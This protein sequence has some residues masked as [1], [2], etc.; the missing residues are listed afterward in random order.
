[1]DYCDFLLGGIKKGERKRKNLE[2][3]FILE[4]R[5]TM[6]THNEVFKHMF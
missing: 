5:T 1:M 6:E 2:S 4:A 3:Q